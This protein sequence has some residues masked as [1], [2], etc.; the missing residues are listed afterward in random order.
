MYYVIKCRVFLDLT[1]LAG[2]AKLLDDA[3][4]VLRCAIVDFMFN[5]YV[6]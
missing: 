5:Y 1:L 4:F 6:K 3:I 2:I